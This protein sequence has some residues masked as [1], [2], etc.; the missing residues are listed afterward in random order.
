MQSKY[1]SNFGRAFGKS[2]KGWRNESA[3]H[4]LASRGISTGRKCSMSFAKDNYITPIKNKEYKCDRCGAV[5]IQDTNHY[6]KIYNLR[7]PNCSWKNPMQPFVTM[8]CM[9]K[10]PKGVGLPPEWK[11]ATLGGMMKGKDIDPKFKKYMKEFVKDKVNFA[12]KSQGTV[13]NI[14]DKV[15]EKGNQ[16]KIP[17]G[18]KLVGIDKTRTGEVQ[19]SRVPFDDKVMISVWIAEQKPISIDRK[20]MGITKIIRNRNYIR[21]VH[22]K[23]A[24]VITSNFLGDVIAESKRKVAN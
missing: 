5:S 10:P 3:R 12:K 17:L 4:S 13:Y 23:H 8:T 15:M 18:E 9:E 2:S 20:T 11:T 14:I 22:T 24:R 21:S 6:G 7:C 16:I 1:K 19:V